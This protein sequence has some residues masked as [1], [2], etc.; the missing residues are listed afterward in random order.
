MCVKCLKEGYFDY[1]ST[2]KSTKKN[3]FLNSNKIS[4]ARPQ[5]IP[6]V[7]EDWWT[8]HANI[9][10]INL[11]NCHIRYASFLHPIHTNA[12]KLLIVIDCNESL[13]EYSYFIKQMYD[14]NI[15]V[16]IYDHRSQGIYV[17]IYTY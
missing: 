4:N 17:S 10:S 11:N 12:C 5:W 16:W 8:H 13:L 7:E 6:L 9:N 2:P 15:D 1:T 3:N 14:Q